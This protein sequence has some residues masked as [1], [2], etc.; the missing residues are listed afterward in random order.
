MDEAHNLLS[1]SRDMFS[2]CLSI[3]ELEKIKKVVKK[4]DN[5]RIK[6]AI[7]KL[8]RNINLLKKMDFSQDEMIIEQIDDDFIY[9]IKNLYDAINEY[10]DKG[11]FKGINNEIGKIYRFIKTYSNLTNGYKII[12]SSK[13][14]D[15]TFNL[16]CIDAS[17]F[18]RNKKALF[19]SNIFFSAT[20]SPMDFF[21]NTLLGND[22]YD[23]KRISSPFDSKNFKV[24]IDAK[25]SINYKDRKFT[26]NTV[27]DEIMLYIS[28]KVGNYIV[29]VPSFEYL[30]LLKDKINDSL[31][32]F[33]KRNMKSHDREEFIN[34][35]E[36]NPAKTHVGV[37]VLGGTFSEGLDL[38]GDRLI[39]VVVIGV[40]L[41]QINF[42]NNLIKDYYEEKN[43]KGFAFAYSNPGINKVLQAMGRVIRTDEDVGSALLID[44]RFGYKE[45]KSTILE[46][47]ENTIFIDKKTDILKELTTFYKK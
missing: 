6:S 12:L 9:S 27:V 18:I 1:R 36:T 28:V 24:L 17:E 32:I 41:P 25:T 33:Q 7:R 23:K 29:F 14:D 8:S 30:E 44:K 26:I 13:N 42:E 16:K 45:Y 19:Y 20:L 38:T 37:C 47:Y 43:G 31:F 3:S 40:G 34:K 5:K 39:G 11:D 2:E 15:I 35:F 21:V 22:N 46:K 10:K 4:T